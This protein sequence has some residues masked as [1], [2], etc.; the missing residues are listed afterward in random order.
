[1]RP[2][3]VVLVSLMISALLSAGLVHAN[4]INCND[5]ARHVDLKEGGT[6]AAGAEED[7][8][9]GLFRCKP[10]EFRGDDP[11][12]VR[13][14]IQIDEIQGL[15][16]DHW[17]AG[18]ILNIVDQGILPVQK[19]QRIDPD[20]PV[21]LY[22]A[23]RWILSDMKVDLT[24]LSPQ[25]IAQKAADLN[26][27][28]ETNV[29]LDRELTRLD[30]VMLISRMAGYTGPVQQE[31]DMRTVYTDWD[32]VPEQYRDQLYFVTMQSRL[33]VGFPDKTF[34]PRAILTL[35]QFAAAVE[36]VLLLP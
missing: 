7:D 25:Q 31:V 24:G 15:T 1:M 5:N 11:S 29:G 16:A 8:F 20:K 10:M 4:P 35:A 3:R 12:I 28:G 2:V 14:W 6:A 32:L 22:E 18:H 23:A 9:S 27:L 33:F 13:R 21:M 19:G 34:R 26:L 17:A 30:A 36:R